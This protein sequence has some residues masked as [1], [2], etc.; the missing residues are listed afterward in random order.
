MYYILFNA[1]TN[2]I[3]AQAAGNY[4]MA[5]KIL[6]TAQQNTEDIFMSE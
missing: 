1:I 5:M 3:E 4:E 6:I 2:A